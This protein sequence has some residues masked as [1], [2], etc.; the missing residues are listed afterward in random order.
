MRLIVRT[1]TALAI[2]ATVIVG[3]GPSC[4][5]TGGG[6]SYSTSVRYSD[7]YRTGGLGPGYGCSRIPAPSQ[8]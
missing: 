1:L 6:W 5:S 4:T 8:C 7:P 3:A 2:A